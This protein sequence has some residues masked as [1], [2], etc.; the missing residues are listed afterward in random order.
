M[1]FQK[2]I[3]DGINFCMSGI[4]YWNTDTG[5]FIGG[6]PK[7]PVYAELFYPMVSV[8]R[9]LSYVSSFM[10][11]AAPKEM[12]RFDDATEKNSHRVR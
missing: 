10:E 5:G 3:P 1:F 2:Q 12:W 8:Q 6:D 7:D 4:P 11:R 9:I